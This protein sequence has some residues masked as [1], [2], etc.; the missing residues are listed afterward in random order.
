MF[1]TSREDLGR[2][3]FAWSPAWETLQAVRTLIDPRARLHHDSWYAAIAGE[4]A[5]L[6]LMQLL[7][8]NPLR[9]SVPDFLAP[10]PRTPAPAFHD[11]L[12]EIRSTPA[13][14]VAKDLK[15]CQATLRGAA[16]ETVD[17]MLAGPATAR[18]LLAD[19]LHAAWEQLVAPLWPRIQAV[20]D[21]D[22]AHRSRQ[23]TDH[24]LCSMLDRIDPRIAWKDGTVIVDDGV[25]LTAEPRGR[26][27]VLMPSVYLW[28]AVIAIADEPWQPAIA[29]PARGIADLWRPSAPPDALA[30]LLG[31]TRALLLARLDRPAST[32]TLARLH[33]LSPGGTSKHLLAMRDAGLLAGTRYGHEVR[34]ER[35]RLGNELVRRAERTGRPMQ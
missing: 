33:G 35:T 7:A 3:R 26:G 19:Q 8:V 22:V 17:A 34:Y 23:L 28:P 12:A 5:R 32:T 21:T 15:R 14:Q 4:A 16:L 24:G 10:P 18:D 27:L 2:V 29:Y 11:Q 9:G 25:D 30:R 1:A 20:L 6:H 31:R 13:T